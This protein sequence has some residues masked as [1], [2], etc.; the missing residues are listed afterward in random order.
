MSKIRFKSF[1][2]EFSVQMTDIILKDMYCECIKSKNNETGGILI[3]KYS[4][5]RSIAFIIE[6]TGPPKNSK[7]KKYTF[8]RGV[9]GLNE[10]LDNRWD[11][12]Y[13]YIGD[14]HFHPNSS[15][16]PSM[17]D[18]MQM[19]KFA[20]DKLLNCPEPILLIIGGNNSNGWEF[21]LHVYTK[22]RRVTLVNRSRFNVLR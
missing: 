18:D 14:W 3:G 1:D 5:D 7:Q 10:I 15:P 6:I 21:S 20:N 13:R 9:D 16:I 22:K 4:E 17:I 11:L 12:G 19:K 8:E 2:D